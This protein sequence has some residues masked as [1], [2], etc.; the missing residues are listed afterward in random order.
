MIFSRKNVKFKLLFNDPKWL[1]ENISHLGKPEIHRL[2]LVP[3]GMGYVSFQKD[4][5]IF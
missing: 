2:K 1:G 5:S 3:A 4:S